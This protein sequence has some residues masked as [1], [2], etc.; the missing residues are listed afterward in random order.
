M[1]P[2]I[3][4]PF[5]NPFCRKGYAIRTGSVPTTAIA[6]RT[7]LLGSVVMLDT[8]PPMVDNEVILLIIS[9]STFCIL[10]RLESVR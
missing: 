8:E 10:Y 6:I 2:P 7:V 1:T 3:T 9:F 4:I 5:T